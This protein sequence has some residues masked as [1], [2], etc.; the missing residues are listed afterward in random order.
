VL[1]H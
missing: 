1:V